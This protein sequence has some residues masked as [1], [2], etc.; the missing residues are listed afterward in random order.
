VGVLFG[1]GFSGQLPL[2]GP[3]DDVGQVL[4]SI[5]E[6]EIAWPV[7]FN[8]CRQLGWKLMDPTSGRMF[9]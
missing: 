3:N 4:V 2:V 1:P 7:L 6:D 5:S 9:G 8:I